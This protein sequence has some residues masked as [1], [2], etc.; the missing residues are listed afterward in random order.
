SEASRAPALPAAPSLDTSAPR[1]DEVAAVERKERAS[2]ESTPG[3]GTSPAAEPASSEDLAF[4]SPAPEREAS[5]PRASA[6]K[7]TA[8]ATLAPESSTSSTSSASSPRFGARIAALSRDRRW[9]GLVLGLWIGCGLLGFAGLLFSWSSLR[10]RMLGR[11]RLR[12]GE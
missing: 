1:P 12:D 11:T 6:R 9:P 2:S 10:R 5:K 8:P 4:L 3:T 7:H